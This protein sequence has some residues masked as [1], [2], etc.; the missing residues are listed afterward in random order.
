[1]SNWGRPRIW[2]IRVSGHFMVILK[3]STPMDNKI[4]INNLLRQPC[5][6]SL[7]G[8]H[9]ILLLPLN[10]PAHGQYTVADIFKHTALLQYFTQCL[11]L[12]HIQPLFR[13]PTTRSMICCRECL[14]HHINSCLHIHGLRIEHR[15]DTGNFDKLADKLIVLIVVDNP[16]DARKRGFMYLGEP[17]GINKPDFHLAPAQHFLDARLFARC[18]GQTAQI[19]D[20]VFARFDLTLKGMADFMQQGHNIARFM[21]G[22]FHR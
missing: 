10:Q 9:G 4:V 12:F 15:G 21:C 1:V 14:I 20:G 3:P 19:D 8:D 13:I 6:L 2:S 5:V 18:H 7:K 17:Q 16:P 11:I 22:G